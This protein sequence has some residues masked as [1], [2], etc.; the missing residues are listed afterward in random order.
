MSV[1]VNLVAV[2]L[3]FQIALGYVLKVRGRVGSEV[4][5]FP[6]GVEQGAQAKEE[7]NTHLDR[8]A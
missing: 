6:V 7:R 5:E 8:A 4:Q 2:E 3:P 1:V